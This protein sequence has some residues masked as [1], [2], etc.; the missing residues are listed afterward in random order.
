MSILSVKNLSHSYNSGKTWAIN[1]L[2]FELSEYGTVG[3]LG[4]NGAGKSTTMNII[5]G[6][7]NQTRGEIFLDG[8][9]LKTSPRDAKKFLGYLPQDPPLYNDL[10]VYEYLN[11]CAKIRL[12]PEPEITRAIDSAMQKVQIEH[13]KNRLIKNLSGGYKQRV[14]IAQAII[15]SPSLVVFDEPTV[16]LD[17]NQIVEM[18]KLIKN[19]SEKSL[20]LISSHILSEIDLLCQHIILIDQGKLIFNGDIT[21]FRKLESKNKILIKF[22]NPP[23]IQKIIGIIGVAHAEYTDSGYLA[24]VPENDS[25]IDKI[26]ELSVLEH[27]SIREITTENKSL[28]NVFVNITSK[29]KSFSK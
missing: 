14:G 20:V 12:M 16:G 4:S 26:L 15:H 13:F 18:R 11:H 24:I 19:I 25:V 9:N 7:L 8:I 22:V 6:V 21:S 3:L 23:L 28:D 2:N 29:A 5:C 17:P 10:T 27:W 1:D